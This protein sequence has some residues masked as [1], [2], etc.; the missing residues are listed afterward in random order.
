MGSLKKSPK[1]SIIEK[2]QSYLA[3]VQPEEGGWEHVLENLKTYIFSNTKENDREINVKINYFEKSI[4]DLKERF[5]ESLSKFQ[6]IQME[7]WLGQS[8]EKFGAWNKALAAY[9]I[10]L[11]NCESGNHDLL[12]SET[13]RQ[14]GHIHLMRN[15]W[16]DAIAAYQQCLILSQN[17]SDQEG[18]AYAYSSLGIVYF[19]Q[20]KFDLA[21]SDWER[22]LEIAE[23]LEDAKISAQ[24]YNNMGALMSSQG[25]WE[26]ALTYYNKS[27]ALFEQLGEFRGLAETYHNMGMTYADL[28]NWP[29]ANS[30]YEKS[31]EIAKNIGDVRLQA[32]VKLNRVELYIS[33]ND[34]YAGLAIGNQALQTFLQLGDR[35]GEAE[36]YKFMGMLYTK[37][38][39]WE[40]AS[41]YFEQSIYLAGKYN[42][43]LLE[44]ESYLEFGRMFK[45]KGDNKLAINNLNKS[46]EIFKKLD[47]KN[48]I[49]KVELELAELK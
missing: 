34:V 39:R 12:K 21:S 26:Q 31:H 45:L 49:Q 37:I 30:F 29:E 38:K 5:S 6:Q 10:A 32:L 42:N 4:A 33:I 44:S 9:Q 27:S 16:E 25:K 47:A 35:L 48:D 40:L 43:P 18:E 13:L 24:I 11:Q 28:H 41:T 46:L 23:Q 20:G 17:A 22:G 1:D 7:I 3:H 2:L 36:T 8:Y 15:E 14:I 19:E